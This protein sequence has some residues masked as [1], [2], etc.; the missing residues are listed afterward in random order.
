[1]KHW[2]LSLL[3]TAALILALTFPA[4][5]PPAPTRKTI[6]N[7]AWLSRFPRL[8]PILPRFEKLSHR[9]AQGTRERLD[10]AAHDFGG[11]R[12]EAIKATDEA[13]RQLQLCLEFDK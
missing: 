1:M 7:P 9:S 10:H 5:V 6:R 13:I 12:V 8:R 11:H 4:A 2:I 3:A